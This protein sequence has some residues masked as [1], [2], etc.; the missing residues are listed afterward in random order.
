[1]FYQIYVNYWLPLRKDC[2]TDALLFIVLRFESYKSE[3]NPGQL[4]S[5]KRIN[6]MTTERC[7]NSRSANLPRLHRF[8]RRPSTENRTLNRPCRGIGI[9]ALVLP[10]S[11][12]TTTTTL[13]PNRIMSRLRS[14]FYVCRGSANIAFP[15]K[16]RHKTSNQLST[17]SYVTLAW[18]D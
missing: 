11:A 16:H 15:C 5:E 3:A 9:A 17:G 10:L 6:Q 7:E 18:Q 4:I 1:M 13:I 14:I 2:H 12:A 8:R